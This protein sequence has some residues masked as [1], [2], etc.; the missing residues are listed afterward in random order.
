[1]SEHKGSVAD[2]LTTVYFIV[3]SVWAFWNGYALSWL[4]GVPLG[5]G[6]YLVVRSV[7]NSMERRK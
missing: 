4:V 6:A 5:V 2:G 3:L 1:M 7:Y